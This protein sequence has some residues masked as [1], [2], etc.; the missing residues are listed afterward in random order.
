MLPTIG[1][2]D[3][4]LVLGPPQLS[5][6]GGP[7][8]QIAPPSLTQPHEIQGFRRFRQRQRQVPITDRTESEYGPDSPLEEFWQFCQYP[9]LA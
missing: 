5:R 6:S 7:V 3:S 2:G 8:Q 9:I 4:S 1:T